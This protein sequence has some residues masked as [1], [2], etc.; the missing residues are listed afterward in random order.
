MGGILD[1]G[2]LGSGS[3][4]Y[5]GKNGKPRETAGNHQETIQKHHL[6]GRR[7]LGLCNL[8]AKVLKSME[9]SRRTT[10]SPVTAVVGRHG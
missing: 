9:Q 10:S 5:W 6:S 1:L 7:G 4:S 3:R 8:C 2:A